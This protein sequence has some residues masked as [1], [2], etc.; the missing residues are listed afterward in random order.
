MARGRLAGAITLDHPTT[1]TAPTPAHDDTAYLDVSYLDDCFIG[2][3]EPAAPTDTAAPTPSE[4][5]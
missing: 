3:D 5:E 1:P 2:S 4:E